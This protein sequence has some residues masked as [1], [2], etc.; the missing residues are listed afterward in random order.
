MTTQ[1]ASV[2]ADL[3]S[4]RLAV[5]ARLDA[6]DLALDNLGRV[7]GEPVRAVKDKPSKP[8]KPQAVKRFSSVTSLDADTRRDQLLTVIKKFDVGVTM[9][10]LR[11]ALPNMDGK[12]R[13]NALQNLKTSG[14]IRRAGNTWKAA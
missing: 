4:E 14:A 2:L 11:K 8:S 3:R 13:S 6:I 9:A 12:A 5:A 7:Y 10:E 1:I